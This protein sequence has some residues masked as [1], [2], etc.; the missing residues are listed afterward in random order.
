[1][2]TLTKIDSTINTNNVVMENEAFI[3]PITK[4]YTDIKH[5]IKKTSKLKFKS[6]DHID[7][8]HIPNIINN[9]S[10][11]LVNRMAPPTPPPS[12]MVPPPWWT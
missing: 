9:P 2:P 7:N 8:E 1:M 12:Q 5:N 6:T 11:P 4:Q 10:G 3:Q